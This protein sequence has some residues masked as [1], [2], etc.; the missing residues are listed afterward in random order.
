MAPT[1]EQ[2]DSEVKKIRNYVFHDLELI[3]KQQT[4]GNYAAIAIMLCAC[5]LF[6]R[7]RYCRRDEGW[8]FV[9]DYMGTLNANYAK[10][11]KTLYD[12]L[13][14][15]IMHSYE[16]KKVR[17]G[18]RLIDFG[19]SWRE[20][21]HFSVDSEKSRIH[22]NVPAIHSDLTQAFEAYVEDLKKNGQ[23]RDNFRNMLRKDAETAPK[24]E[25][26]KK[27]LLAYF[28]SASRE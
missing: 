17:I 7:L 3:V 11:G 25:S 2:I 15:G 9:V 24:D 22:I 6:A 21:Q 16:T 28:N 19:I 10:I 13:R 12:A 8:R 20:K 4:G 23:L 18:N 14:H 26:E 1:F 5:D 27:A